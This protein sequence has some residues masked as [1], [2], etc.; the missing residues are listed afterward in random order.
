MKKF[1]VLIL[2]VALVL[3]TFALV[4]C[5]N[6]DPVESGVPPVTDNDDKDFV[7]ALSAQNYASERLAVEAFVAAELGCTFVSYE[8]IGELD[9]E[10]ISKLNIDNVDVASIRSVKRAQIKYT[11][12]SMGQRRATARDEA[13]L[14]RAAGEKTIDC[15]ILESST[16]EF[17][18]YALASENGSP[19][20]R[21]YF[22]HVFN[23][24]LFVNSKV[25]F[26][27]ERNFGDSPITDRRATSVNKT[28][29][30]YICDGIIKLDCM[31][32]GNTEG[33]DGYEQE[34]TIYFVNSQDVIYEVYVAADDGAEVRYDVNKSDRTW[35]QAILSVFDEEDEYPCYCYNKTENG[36]EANSDYW[37]EWYADLMDMPLQSDM[38]SAEKVYTVTDGRV[39]HIKRDIKWTQLAQRNATGAG[40]EDIFEKIDVAIT[41]MAEQDK[42]VAS[43]EITKA[44]DD[45]KA[46]EK[47]AEEERKKYTDLQGDAGSVSSEQVTEEQWVSALNFAGMDNVTIDYK[48]VSISDDGY[49]IHYAFISHEYDANKLR[50]ESG[51]VHVLGS[52]IQT[53]PSEEKFAEIDTENNVRYDYSYSSGDHGWR[54]SSSHIN[55]PNNNDDSTVA[56]Y[57]KYV[58]GVLI[59]RFDDFVYATDGNAL[60][61][62]VAYFDPADSGENFKITV[63]IV[64]G[65]LVYWESYNLDNRYGE[66]F[67]FSKIGDT[68]VTLPENVIENA[69][70]DNDDKVLSAA[71]FA[72]AFDFSDVTNGTTKQI[73]FG[74]TETVSTWIYTSYVDGSKTKTVTQV[75]DEDDNLVRET[76]SFGGGNLIIVNIDAFNRYIQGYIGMEDVS[77]SNSFDMFSYDDETGAYVAELKH[78]VYAD[79]DESEDTQY[80]DL[81]ITVTI[82]DGKVS[83]GLIYCDYEDS[84]YFGIFTAEFYDIGNTVVETE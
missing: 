58:Y 83:V 9:D 53:N 48:T 42:V 77:L 74:S 41:D 51:S 64:N 34:Y 19:I 36:F 55:D 4:A 16:G 49:S 44:I 25:V 33:G 69:G 24:S 65:K 32:Y 1:L 14:V 80:V 39:S 37:D 6:T 60:G 10:Q 45:Y 78:L 40:T 67:Y 56:S 81:T 26:T 43:S 3:P 12:E 71:D 15:L 70:D 23:P 46:A 7:G 2:A 35:E 27:Y 61:Q 84:D 66:S 17:Y 63:K 52:Y 57:M 31:D 62:Y 59:S 18:Y 22:D 68:S 13:Q 47:A 28:N 29:T 21:S 20:T 30:V 11:S 8:F 38:T 73:I 76:E 50:T 54:I 79:Q 72:A 82:V 75:Y 5:D